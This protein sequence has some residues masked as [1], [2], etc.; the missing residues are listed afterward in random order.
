MSYPELTR[1]SSIHALASTSGSSAW[2]F[3]V[4]VP[5][6]IFWLV[7]AAI[8]LAVAWTRFNQPPTNRSGTTFFL[9]WCGLIFY[10]ALL[11]LLWILV[12]AVLSGSPVFDFSNM[13]EWL[14]KSAAPIVALLIVAVASL[15]ARVHQFDL[16]ARHLCLQFA[17]IPRESDSL[18][19][20]LSQNAVFKPPTEQLKDIVTREITEN[21]GAHAVNFDNDGR[22]AAR[23]TKVVALH[24]LF[25]AP[26]VNGS[27]LPFPHNSHGKSKYARVMRE[28]DELVSVANAGYHSMLEL[29][30]DVFSSKKPKSGKLKLLKEQLNDLS[31]I[32]CQMIAHYILA[33]DA[34]SS[35]RRRR[36]WKMGFDAHDYLP[37][38]GRDQAVAAILAMAI[39][40]ILVSI[41]L[42]T[43]LQFSKVLSIGII[44]A[45]QNGLAAIAGALVAQR[46]IRGDEGNGKLRFP[47]FMELFIASAL[48]VVL[49]ATLSFARHT[50]PVFF[51]EGD[52]RPAVEAFYGGLPWLFLPF[53]G[54]FTIGLLCS[55]FSPSSLNRLS[56]ASIGSL[57]YGLT[58]IAGAAL[59]APLVGRNPIWAAAFNGVI[60]FA[61]GGFVL[62]TFR[63]SNRSL[64]TLRETL[65]HAEHGPDE[66]AARL[67]VGGYSRAAVMELE[68]LYLCVRPTFGNPEIINAYLTIIRWDET[69]RCLLFEEKDRP[70]GRHTQSGTVYVPD[71]KP[72]MNLVTASRGAVRLIMITRPDAEGLARGLVF[73]LSNPGGVNFIPAATPIVLRRISGEIPRLGFVHP[74]NPEHQ[75]YMSLVQGVMPTFGLLASPVMARTVINQV[76]ALQKTT[77]SARSA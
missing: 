27:P 29:A 76:G 38:F 11:V 65:K 60:G 53:I 48:V 34:M 62:A 56:V 32:I 68:G 41:V 21:I 25:I 36:M 71:G 23:F 30:V 52:L 43:G 6:Q 51:T 58:Q 31:N 10:F 72:F 64:G 19:I 2:V 44:V 46:F 61:L 42:P 33:Q 77:G 26:F 55:Y 63:R 20:E 57:T 15:F 5:Y 70:D 40:F 3:V 37:A 9:F 13:P 39:L 24:W 74:V 67:E 28:Y 16:A 54:T 4:D 47:P 22:L 17:A 59:V 75:D 66:G 69:Q 12:A 50:T 73:T 18:A 14:K 35:G 7:P 8:L 49:S 45:I 1:L